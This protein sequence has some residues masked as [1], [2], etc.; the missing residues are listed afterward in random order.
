[1]K[2]RFD[3]DPQSCDYGA[4]TLA[5]RQ[6]LTEWANIDWF[7]P[8]GDDAIA[9]TLFH[10]H[11]AKAQNVMPDVFPKHLHIRSAK[12][13]W[14]EFRALCTQV[15]V[16]NDTWDWKYSAL[17]KLSRLHSQE[18]GWS[19]EAHA[20]VVTVESPPEPSDLFF[21]I[22][23]VALWQAIGPK[24]AFND[25]LSPEDADLA[26]WY[27]SYATLDLME[28]LEWQL[29]EGSNHLEGNAFVPLLR[30][31]AAGRYPFGLSPDEVVLFGFTNDL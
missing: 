5:V 25:L 10:E 16:A 12:G 9:T 19:L 15:R 8:A 1:M 20:R 2:G 6:I 13:S 23:K 29:A 7:A 24:I 14:K 27:H 28:G 31:Y 22:G 30:C 3:F 18:R 17:K 4:A 26:A 11:N 21:R